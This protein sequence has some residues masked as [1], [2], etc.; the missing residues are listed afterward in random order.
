MTLATIF[1][2]FIALL[3][4]ACYFASKKMLKEDFSSSAK[5]KNYESSNTVARPQVK[6]YEMNYNF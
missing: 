5:N 6:R 4:I 2:T 3:A 1:L